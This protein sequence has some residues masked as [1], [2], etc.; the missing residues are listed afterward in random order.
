M[1]LGKIIAIALGVTFSIGAIASDRATYTA[2]KS[3]RGNT[4]NI[5]ES[6]VIELCGDIDGCTVRIG[7]YNWNGTRRTASRETLFY[8]N[9]YSRNWRASAGDVEGTTDNNST[10]HIIN[11]WSCYFTDGN[12]SQYYNHGD[13]NRNFAVLSWNQYNA[14]CR[15]TLID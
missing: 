13:L 7:M 9:S 3:Q 5:P 6:K 10:Q 15:V 1:K 2:Y 14:D 4:V 11:A 8:Y 12:Y